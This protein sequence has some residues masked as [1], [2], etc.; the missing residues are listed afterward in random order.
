MAPPASHVDICIFSSS[1]EKRSRS[2]IRHTWN[3]RSYCNRIYWSALLDATQQPMGAFAGARYIMCC[4]R[5]NISSCKV[6]QTHHVAH[7]CFKM[8]NLKLGPTFTRILTGVRHNTV[9]PADEELNTIRINFIFE[10][11]MYLVNSKPPN[12]LYFKSCVP[13]EAF[14]AKRM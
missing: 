2:N 4:F 10:R 14:L 3:G 9:A 13:Q 5:W 12:G 7:A 6:G 11:Q 1:E 8:I